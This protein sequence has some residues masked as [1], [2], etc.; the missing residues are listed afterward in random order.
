MILDTLGTAMSPHRLRLK[1]GIL[2]RLGNFRAVEQSAM[3]VY[4]PVGLIPG[5]Q[6]PLGVYENSPNTQRDAIVFSDKAIWIESSGAFREVHYAD[7]RT[8]R[9]SPESKRSAN[10]LVLVLADGTESVIKVLGRDSQAADVFSVQR[11]L[12]HSAPNG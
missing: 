12:L 10:S 6:Q 5:D 9:S 11:F 7:I 2:K 8:V 3:P 4:L 1:V